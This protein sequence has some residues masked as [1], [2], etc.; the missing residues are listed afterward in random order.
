VCMETDLVLRSTRCWA[1]VM[2]CKVSRS[3][4]YRRGKGMDEDVS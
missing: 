2:T 1:H 3:D 4:I